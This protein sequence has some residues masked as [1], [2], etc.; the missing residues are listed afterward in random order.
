MFPHSPHIGYRIRVPGESRTRQSGPENLR[1][2]LDALRDGLARSRF[3]RAA[4]LLGAGASDGLI[5]TMGGILAAVAR[6]T[7]S[8]APAPGAPSG[9]AALLQTTL[10]SWQRKVLGTLGPAK[11]GAA[12]DLL[13]GPAPNFLEILDLGSDENRHS[14]VIRWLLDPRCAPTI[15]P[16]ALGALATRLDDPVVWA[17][18]IRR[19]IDTD[20]LSV[21][22]E[23]TIAFEWTDES[24]LDRIDIVISSPRFVLAV[25]NKLWAREHGEQ[26]RRYWDWLSCLT[27]RRAGLF[28]SPSGFPP[29]SEGFKAM[30]YLELLSCFLEGFQSTPTR[31]EQLVL[32]GYVKMLAAGILISELRAITRG[33]GHVT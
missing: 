11:I 20:S 9:I 25:E 14:A 15:A 12:R 18:E 23:Y 8:I 10:D 22:R 26:T 19:A 16:P 5:Q 32:S 3:P 1:R 4:P 13:A 6:H 30:S 24:R 17:T 33:G 29:A 21:H 31:E 28:L 27:V 2:L 7:R